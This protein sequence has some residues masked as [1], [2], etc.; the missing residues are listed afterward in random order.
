M[1]DTND[2]TLDL[3]ALTERELDAFLAGVTYGFLQGEDAGYTRGH[4]ARRRRAVSNPA[5]SSPGRARRRPS[6]AERRESSPGMGSAGVNYGSE[7]RQPG[8]GNRVGCAGHR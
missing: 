4:A 3:A 7:V 8:S 2:R 6:R 1:S 5:T